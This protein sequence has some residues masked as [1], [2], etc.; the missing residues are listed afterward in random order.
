LQDK[1]IR[2]L[3]VTISNFADMEPTYEE[4]FQLTLF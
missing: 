3:G 1:R 2:L 4:G